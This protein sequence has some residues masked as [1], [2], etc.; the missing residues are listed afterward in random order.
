MAKTANKGEWS[1]LYAFFKLLGDKILYKGDENLNRLKDIYYPIIKIIREN[2]YYNI[3]SE[4]EIIFITENGN[5]INKISVGEFK[6]NANILLNKIRTNSG[7][8]A[9]SEIED[10]MN[11]SLCSSIK[12]PSTDKTDIKI[13]IHDIQTG[14]SPTLGF[15]IKSNLGAKSTLVNTSK[16][17]EFIYDIN[18]YHFSKDEIVEINSISTRSKIK[19]RINKIFEKG[20]KLH[21]SHMTSPTFSNNLIIIDSLLPYIMSEMILMYFCNSISDL[22]QISKKLQEINPIGYDTSLSHKFYEYKIKHFLTDVALGLLPSKRWNG[23]YDANGGFLIVKEDGEVLCYHIYD[24]YYFE[25]YLINNT[26]FDTPSS[27]RHEYGTIEELEGKQ[28]FKLNFQI[29]FK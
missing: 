18:D 4:S 17:T 28:F 14:I 21:F 10:F 15:S 2:K 12:A 20:G 29:R 1:E 25:E 8:F 26:R 19:D 7:A 5:E 6:K 24:K 23:N 11:L 22:N 16:A 13:I 27:S 9:I 3:D